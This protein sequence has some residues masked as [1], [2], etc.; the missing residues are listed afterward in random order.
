MSPIIAGLIMI[1]VA[2]IIIFVIIKFVK[3]CNGDEHAD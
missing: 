1:A 2:F 3:L